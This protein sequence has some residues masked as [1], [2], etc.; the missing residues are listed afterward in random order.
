MYVDFESLPVIAVIDEKQNGIYAV[1]G[2]QVGTGEILLRLM[3]E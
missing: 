1:S 3:E 2:Y